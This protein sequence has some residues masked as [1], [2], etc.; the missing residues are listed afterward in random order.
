ML[1]AAPRVT[2]IVLNWNGAELLPDC[3]TSLRRQ[4]CQDF[5]LLLVDNGSTDGSAELVARDFPEA[6]LIA[7]PEN[8]GFCGG[9]NVGFREARG[10]LILLLNNDAELREDFVANVIAAADLE[11][12]FG[13]FAANVRMYDRRE[14]FDST[15]LLVYADGVCRS[16]GWLEKDVGQFDRADEVLAPNGC[17]AVYRRA[18]LDDVGLFDEAYFAYLEDLDLGLRGQ[19][20]GW[21]CRYLPGAVAYHKKSMTS[22]YHSAFKAHLVERNRIWNAVRLLPLRLLALSP[23]WTLARYVAQGF[24]AASGRGMSSTFSRDYTRGQLAGILLRAYVE[25]LARLPEVWRQRQ[26]IQGRRKLGALAVYV[27]L[28]RHRLPLL[29]LAFKD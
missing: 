18:M 17:A 12:D 20:R 29:E 9:N 25:A 28:R 4:T 26:E 6:R 23:F 16:R 2:I 8:R 24:A 19:L 13:M 21:R 15:G 3:L 27:L 5:E 10:E 22:G 11:P 7:L 1:T 14:V